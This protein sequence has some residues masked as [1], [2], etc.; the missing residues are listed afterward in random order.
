MKNI[1]YLVF[2]GGG[3]KAYMMLGGFDILN[4]YILYNKIKGVAGTSI[5][6]VISFFYSIDIKYQEVEELLNPYLF[7]KSLGIYYHLVFRNIVKRLSFNTIGMIDEEEMFNLDNFTMDNYYTEINEKKFRFF[8]NK[9]LKIKGIP[10]DINFAD[11][12]LITKK[13]L[14]VVC[15]DII[16]KKQVNFSHKTTPY[17]KV[18]KALMA[19][20]NLPYVF[21]CIQFKDEDFSN[22]EISYL[23]KNK[24]FCDG[25]VI[26]NYPI[27]IF[28]NLL[29][30]HQK[31]KNVLGVF[32]SN[33][34]F[35]INNLKNKDYER[36][37]MVENIAK[38]DTIQFLKDLKKKKMVYFGKKSIIN[39]LNQR[40]FIL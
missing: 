25:G 9:Y 21:K 26:N 24:Y 27:N 29:K 30:N 7:Y 11:L 31:Y 1:E 10:E 13:H 4:N 34:N 8:I 28:D 33:H 2:S 15:C 18:F 12:Y 38:V 3:V 16:N 22:K 5:G 36:T 23:V 17:M 14:I 20:V 37:V 32:L 19:S 39:Y 35:A 40:F 6:S